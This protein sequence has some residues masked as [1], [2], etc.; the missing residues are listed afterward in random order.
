MKLKYFCKKHSKIISNYSKILPDIQYL[1]NYINVQK[2][3]KNELQITLIKDAPIC[4]VDNL[5]KKLREY[6]FWF[7]TFS[8]ELYIF[9]KR[10]KENKVYIID[11]KR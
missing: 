4:L 1:S 2:F 10:N 9:N 6:N 5:L 11:K 8:N 7:E 3:N